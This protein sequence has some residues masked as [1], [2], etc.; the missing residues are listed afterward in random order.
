MQKKANG[1]KDL[2]SGIVQCAVNLKAVRF[3]GE[4]NHRSNN[5]HVQQV[6]FYFENCKKKV[7]TFLFFIHLSITNKLSFNQ[8]LHQIF[9]LINFLINLYNYQHCQTYTKKIYITVFLT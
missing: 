1:E 7:R 6:V 4:V 8:T 2:I 3:K 9:G 5:I